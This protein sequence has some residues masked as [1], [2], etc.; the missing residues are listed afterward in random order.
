[1][2]LSGRRRMCWLFAGSW[3]SDGILVDGVFRMWESV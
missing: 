3:A 2:H 1:M